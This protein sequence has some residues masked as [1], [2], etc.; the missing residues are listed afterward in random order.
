MLHFSFNDADSSL[1]DFD[2]M[3]YIT[4]D[5]ISKT[6]RLDFCNREEFLLIALE[7]ICEMLRI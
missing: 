2:K 3:R 7:I 6:F 1:S 5:S 4:C